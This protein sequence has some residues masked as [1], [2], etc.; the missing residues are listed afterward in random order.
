M[1]HVKRFGTI[2]GL[3]KRTSGR[4]AAIRSG[5]LA[6]AQ[7]CDRVYLLVRDFFEPVA[8]GARGGRDGRTGEE[9]FSYK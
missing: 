4:R 2:D 6:Q 7:E 8:G 9:F 3:R 1:F 5:D